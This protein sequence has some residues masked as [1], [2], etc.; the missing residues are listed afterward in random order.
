VPNTELLQHLIG[1]QQPNG[2]TSRIEEEFL[3]R[4]LT[5]RTNDEKNTTQTATVLL[6]E[7]QLFTSRK[8]EGCQNKS[9]ATILPQLTSRIDRMLRLDNTTSTLAWGRLSQR[10]CRVGYG[11]IFS[12]IYS[13]FLS[14]LFSAAGYGRRYLPRMG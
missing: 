4:P 11:E 9:T 8:H 12:G 1:Q 5:H 7:I 2:N 6:V 14:F 13:T 3:A 10:I